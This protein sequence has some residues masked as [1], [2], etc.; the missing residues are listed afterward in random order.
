MEQDILISVIVPVYNA[1]KHLV[2]CV[3][4]ILNQTHSHLEVILVDDGAKDNSGAMCD[5]YMQKD[6][7]IRVVHKE[8]EA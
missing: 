5:T 4:S 6:P 7:R 2:R 3:D 8:N 1:E